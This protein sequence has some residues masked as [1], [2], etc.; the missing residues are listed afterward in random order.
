MRRM[1]F[2]RTCLAQCSTPTGLATVDASDEMKTSPPI[3]SSEAWLFKWSES[4]STSIG[5]LLFSSSSMA[6]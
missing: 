3:F 5:V 6:W 2:S 4:V 1:A